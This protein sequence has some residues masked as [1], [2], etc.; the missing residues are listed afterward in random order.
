MTGAGCTFLGVAPSGHKHLF[1][2]LRPRR[3]VNQIKQVTSERS[4]AQGV[5]N[6]GSGRTN[7]LGS[8]RNNNQSEV[9]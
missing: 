8:V 2:I 4:E 1:A 6:N 3:L 5:E 7:D 9:S